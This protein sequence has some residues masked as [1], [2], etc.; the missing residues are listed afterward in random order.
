MTERR[1]GFIIGLP[2]I[3]VF[4]FRFSFTLAELPPS[5]ARHPTV[6]MGCLAVVYDPSGLFK[7][8]MPFF[9]EEVFSRFFPSSSHSCIF[10]RFISDIFFDNF[11]FTRPA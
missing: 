7:Q 3:F 8:P 10:V 5:V 11:F 1:Y 4:F 6:F 2:V 9:S